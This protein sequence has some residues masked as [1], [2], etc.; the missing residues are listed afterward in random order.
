PGSGLEGSRC[1][2][3]YRDSRLWNVQ[4]QGPEVPLGAKSTNRRVRSGA[5]SA[6]A[7]LQG[8]EGAEGHSRAGLKRPS[9]FNETGRPV[10]GVPFLLSG[11]S[12]GASTASAGRTPPR[13][14]AVADEQEPH[15]L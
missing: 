10:R 5:P 2:Q 1:G 9:G 3:A 14:P 11:F 6:R 12:E 7:G 8:I 13:L 4:G 15:Q